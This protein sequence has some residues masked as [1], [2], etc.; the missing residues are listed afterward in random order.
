[1]VIVCAIQHGPLATF[2]A[3]WVI[4]MSLAGRSAM[5][6]AAYALEQQRVS[7]DTDMCDALRLLLEADASGATTEKT[8]GVCAVQELHKGKA[9]KCAR[10]WPGKFALL[11]EAT[12][13]SET[14]RCLHTKGEGTTEDTITRKCAS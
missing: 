3:A 14:T 2:V 11:Q 4:G 1:M 5:L 7:R 10:G 6:I 12:K 8:W 13:N 9:G